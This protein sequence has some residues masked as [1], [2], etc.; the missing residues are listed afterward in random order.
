MCGVIGYVGSKPC[1]DFI[2]EGLKKLEYRGYDSSG[3][4]TLSKKDGLLRFVKSEGKLEKLKV[5]LPELP[6]D[7]YVGLGHTRWATHGIPSTRNAHP[8]IHNRM[9]IIHNGIFENYK[10]FKS[11]LEKSGSNFNSET[12][13]EVFLHILT[14]ELK[15]AGDLKQAIM[16]WVTRFRGAYALGILTE[17]EPNSMYLVKQ[18]CPLVI[19]LGKGENY[20]AS[21]PVPLSKYTNRFLFLEDGEFARISM[22]QVQIWKFDG[23]EVRREPVL[24]EWSQS[25]VEKQGHRHYM[26]KEI[27]EQP[28][29]ISN[30][31][32]RFLDV[33]KNDIS[34][35]QHDLKNINFSN[36]DRIDITACGTA[37]Y[38]GLIG[39]YILEPILKIPV[40][41]ELASEL[42]Y[43]NPCINSRTL[44][45]AVSQSGETADTLACVKLAK[46][47]GA[48]VLSICNVRFSS[49]ARESDGVIYMEAGPEIGVA[50]TKAFSAMVLNLYFFALGTAKLRGIKLG[51]IEE[52][53]IENLLKLPTLADLA[54]TS[55]KHIAGVA[56]KYFELT[57]TLFVGRGCSF[58]LALEGALKLKEISYIHAEGYAGGELKHGPIALIDHNIAVVSIVSKDNH[59]EKMLSNVEEIRARD[60]RI[61][62]IGSADDEN[63][64]SLCA[65][66]IPCPQI[67]DEALQV[68]L[69]VI[70]LQLFA[71]NVAV[72]RGTDVDQPRNLAKSV[73]VE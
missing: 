60:G 42:R 7:S 14:K 62:G 1:V 27:Y 41:V 39:K 28:A 69:S 50:S 20:F 65:D 12:D 40:N 9:A 56:R 38:A 29:V 68:L 48:Q 25:Q 34:L 6:S 2:F 23:T 71:Y 19:G 22:E 36:F 45:I 52:K 46:T 16:N 11:D 8:H 70:P 18:G 37:Y 33:H 63:F 59:R 51:S 54:I 21:D 67:E 32:E 10:E 44:F 43:R 26:L 35:K 49:I 3:I 30:T 24:L 53:A 61:L 17:E 57:S 55:E 31:I 13:S 4:A 73:T 72:L 47:L 66:Y 58:P 15:V 64:R 5:L